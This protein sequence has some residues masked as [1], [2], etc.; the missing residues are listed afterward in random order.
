MRKTIAT[1]VYEWARTEIIC[2]YC[3]Y[4]HEIEEEHND[5]MECYECEEEFEIDGEQDL[6]F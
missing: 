2:P 5:S 6:I 4:K 1:L 3:G